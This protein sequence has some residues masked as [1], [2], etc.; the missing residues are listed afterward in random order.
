MINIE[1]SKLKEL[2]MLVSN[3]NIRR[4]IDYLYEHPDVEV[5]K[6]Y[7]D[8]GM[9]QGSCSRWLSRMNAANLTLVRTKGVFRYYTIN[10]KMI[11]SI[12]AFVNDGENKADES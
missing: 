7:L 9:I 2:F 8:L 6:I 3:E 1:V 5:T 4:I 11:E 12:N 10:E